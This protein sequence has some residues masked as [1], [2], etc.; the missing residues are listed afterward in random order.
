MKTFASK[1]FISTLLSCLLLLSYTGTFAQGRKKIKK[2]NV[3]TCVV[4]Q[5]ID[6][7]LIIAS[8]STYNEQG[9]LSIEENFTNSGALESI[10][11]YSHNANGE[12]TLERKFNAKEQLLELKTI[13]YNALNQK[14]E[15]VFFDGKY[16]Q[17]KKVVFIY[18]AKGLKAEKRVFDQNNKLVSLKKYAYTYY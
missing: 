2:L 10:K 13:K 17:I 6:N 9:L 16:K 15:E 5:K 11:K 12:I 14:L 1:F 3:H 8:K 4:T 7:K 18:D